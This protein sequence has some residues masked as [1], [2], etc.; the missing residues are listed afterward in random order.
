MLGDQYHEA[1]HD[2]HV[3]YWALVSAFLGGGLPT[4]RACIAR[5]RRVRRLIAGCCPSCGYDLR[6]MTQRCPECGAVPDLRTELAG[7]IL[8]RHAAAV[9]WYASL[10]TAAAAGYIFASMRAQSIEMWTAVSLVVF[11]LGVLVRR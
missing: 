9:H 11:F 3:P 1:R 2:V 7:Q 8:G 5:R 10:L 4:V 6:G